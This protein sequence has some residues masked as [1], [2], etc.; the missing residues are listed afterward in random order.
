MTTATKALIEYLR[1]TELELDDDWLR[2]MVQQFTQGLIE[3]EAEQKIGAARHERSPNRLS[4][5]NGYRERGLA[6]RVG[7]LELRIPKLRTGSF[8]P[9][10]LEPRRR[11]EKAL[12]AVVQEAYVE[13]VS[14]RKVDDLLVALGLN[15][16][17]KSA[18][19]RACKSLDEVIEPFRNRPLS[20]PYPYLW[21]DAL[22]LKVR[23]NQRIVS[24]ALVI[25]IGVGETGERDVLGWALGASEEQAFWQEFL[26]SLVG[27]GLTGVQLVISDAHEGLKAA[28]AQTLT[29]ATWQR[30]RVHFT[31]AP[32][33]RARASAGVRN[34]L[35]HIP[36]G[37]KSLVAATVRTI[38]AQPSR[39]AARAQVDQVA[40]ML[41]Q[42]WPKAATLLRAAEPDILAYMSFPREHWTRI[43]S[44]NPLERLNR[45]VKRRTDV[46]QVFPNDDA[47]LRLA[48]AILLEMAD[49]WAADE[50]HYFSQASMQRLTDPAAA[51]PTVVSG[52]ALAPVR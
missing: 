22:Y 14:T 49:E 2:E 8:F 15:G 42:H 10:L 3:L 4:Q 40:H 30:C 21:L 12:V 17:D 35:A 46:V 11:A 27:R 38:F 47:A 50:R 7:E 23:Q 41:D 33:L 34:L 1:K 44:T 36:Q 19:S 6:T 28:I 5:R 20:G 32:A 43:Y 24:K 9:S 52:P 45:E 16:I 37:D 31:L 26:R 48:G 25:A 39:Q 51:P 13:G 18:V 29:G